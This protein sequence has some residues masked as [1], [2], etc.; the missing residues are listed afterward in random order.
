MTDKRI[1][2]IKVK[3]IIDTTIED[4]TIQEDKENC[5]L[6]LIGMDSLKFITVIVALEEYFK[7]EFP[8]EYL[9]IGNMNTVCKIAE[10]VYSLTTN[11]TT[12]K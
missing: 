9:I 12:E 4:F 7:I 11:A 3:E 5:D 1:I 10:S 8:D 6:S 2:E